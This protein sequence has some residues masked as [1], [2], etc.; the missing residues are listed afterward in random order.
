MKLSERE[1]ESGEEEAEVPLLRSAPIPTCSLES[2]PCDPSTS[3]ST[4]NDNCVGI[5]LQKLNSELKISRV[6]EEEE[7]Q[8][9]RRRRSREEGGGG[10][11][12]NDDSKVN[13]EGR[14]AT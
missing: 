14:K 8:G 11:K 12:I 6:E 10:H 7:E 4:I 9:R 1:R 5:S 13:S 3:A 2:F